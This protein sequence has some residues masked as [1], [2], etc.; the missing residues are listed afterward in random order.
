MVATL[1]GALALIVAVPLS[2]LLA[3]HL[4]HRVPVSALPEDSHAHAH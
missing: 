3:A 2:T 4:L 1:V